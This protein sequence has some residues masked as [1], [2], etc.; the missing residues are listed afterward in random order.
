MHSEAE[1]TETSEF[2]TE[3]VLLQGQARRMGGLCSQTQTPQCFWGEVYTGKIWGQGCR[4]CV[5]SWL[6]GGEVR[7]QCSRTLNYWPSGFSECRVSAHSYHLPPGWGALVSAELKDI[8]WGETKILLSSLLYPVFSLLLIWFCIHL[9][10]PISNCFSWPFGTQGRS[11]GWSLFP[12][13]K[14]WR[15]HMQLKR[16]ICCN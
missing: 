8:L 15:G 4:V 13:N 10:F 3:K 2:G 14:S 5:F 12:T 1:Q 9:F 16:S 6:V 7:R 11:G